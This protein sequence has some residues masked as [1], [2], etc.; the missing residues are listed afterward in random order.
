M[1]QTLKKQIESI[2]K[3]IDYVNSLEEKKYTD[4]WNKNPQSAE[5][6]FTKQ[7]MINSGILFDIPEELEKIKKE[8]RFDPFILF[9]WSLIAIGTILWTALIIY[10]I[11]KAL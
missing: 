8:N 5:T 6:V 1:K 3:G 2:Q 10:L 9:I 11:Q 7:Q 4:I